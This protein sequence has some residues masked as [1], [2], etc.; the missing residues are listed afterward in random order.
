MKT[1]GILNIPHQMCVLTKEECA[2]LLSFKEINSFILTF[3]I[4]LPGVEVFALLLSWICI[5]CM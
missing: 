3:L 4:S 5:S 1:K 2:P